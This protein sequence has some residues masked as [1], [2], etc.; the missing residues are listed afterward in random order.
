M[1]TNK[2]HTLSEFQVVRS[3][4]SVPVHSGQTC[5]SGQ[6]IVVAFFEPASNAPKRPKNAPKRPKTLQNFDPQLGLTFD[7]QSVS[8]TAR[9]HNT[10]QHTHIC[11]GGAGRKCHR[12]RGGRMLT[13]TSPPWVSGRPSVCNRWTVLLWPSNLWTTVSPS[14]ICSRR[15][16]GLD[17]FFFK[18]PRAAAS[19]RNLICKC[20]ASLRCCLLMDACSHAATGISARA[21]GVLRD[22]RAPASCPVPWEQWA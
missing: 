20:Q 18:V 19:S 13:L 6:K 22:E 8:H 16:P 9:T 12:D 10:T 7:P 1:S 14:A 15:Y 21:A 5:R 4:Q 17:P 11:R 3:G 2:Q